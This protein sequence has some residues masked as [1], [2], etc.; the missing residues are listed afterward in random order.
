MYWGLWE[1]NEGY[2]EKALE[3]GIPLHRGPVGKPGR[4]LIY[5]V[6]WEMDEGGSRSIA[7]LSLCDHCEGNL[8][9]GPLLGTLEDVWRKALET[10]I[11]LHR[12]SAGEPGRG[13]IYQGIWKMNEGAL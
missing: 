1:T 8:E 4:G 7:P 10:G 9:G 12:G 13:F 2:V 11:S 5:Q 6:L 3:M